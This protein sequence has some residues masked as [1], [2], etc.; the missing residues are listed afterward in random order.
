MLNRF[1]ISLILLV[2]AANGPTNGAE[3][4]ITPDVVYGHKF[5]MAMT[6]DVFTPT[7]NANGGAVLFVVSGGWFSRWS[8][9]E[10]NIRLAKPLTDKGF[11]VFAIRHGSSPKFSIPEA[12][13]DVRRSVRYIRL[14]A[15]QF[16]VDPN[17]LGIFGMSAGGHLSLM[18]GTA[19]DS[20]DPGAKDPVDRVS[21]RVSAVVAYV[22]PTD[23]RIMV[24]D[25]PD[26]LPAYARFPALNLDLKNAEADS[27]LVHVTSDDA[28]TL[29]LAGDKDQL[30]PISHSR[31]IQSA[32]E[33]ANVESQLI[34]FSGAGH[35][36]QGSDA[37]KAS[38][39]MTAWFETH[40]AT[41]PDN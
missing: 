17:R 32:F 27:P 16:N 15:E 3:I 39:A 10:Q 24:K 7:E 29:L 13:A 41:S 21:N 26:R 8:P 4:S 25:Y 36:F 19:S 37:S 6:F 28:P 2:A 22:A 9:P 35:G 12:I 20:G 31:N 1:Q 38:E 40:L 5:G 11:T 34:E 14:N 18:I 23:L 33:K 30:V